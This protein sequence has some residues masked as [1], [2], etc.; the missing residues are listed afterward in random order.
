MKILP[1]LI[2]NRLSIEYTCLVFIIYIFYILILKPSTL[3]ELRHECLGN[4]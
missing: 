2:V 4:M 3:C 1:S